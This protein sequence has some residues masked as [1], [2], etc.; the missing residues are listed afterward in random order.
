[1]TKGISELDSRIWIITFRIIFDDE[2]KETSYEMAENLH[3]SLMLVTA[4]SPS[5]GYDNAAKVAKKAHA[6]NISLKEATLAMGLM[7]EEEFD[8]VFHPEEMI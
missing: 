1:M 8:R 5:I 3:R 6:E 2:V 7:T 4:L